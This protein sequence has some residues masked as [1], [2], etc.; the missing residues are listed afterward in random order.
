MASPIDRLDTI[1]MDAHHLLKPGPQGLDAPIPYQHSPTRLKA[2]LHV[3]RL[4]QERLNR[5]DRIVHGVL[6]AAKWIT[7]TLV[8]VTLAIFLLTKLAHWAL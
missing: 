8:A 2:Q 7:A 5:S 6:E 4:Q 1:E 3:L